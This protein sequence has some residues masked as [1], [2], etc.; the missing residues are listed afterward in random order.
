MDLVEPEIVGAVEDVRVRDLARRMADR[1]VDIVIADQIFELL[2]EIFAEVA[3]AGDAD[4]VAAGLVQSAEG[5]RR[6]IGRLV[7]AV[8]DAELGISEQAARP[9]L[10]IGPLAAQQIMGQRPAQGG[11]RLVEHLAKLVDDRRNGL[12]VAQ[13]FP[14]RAFPWHGFPPGASPGA[15]RAVIASEHRDEAIQLSA[16]RPTLLLDCR[17]ATLLAMTAEAI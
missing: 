1:N 14:F 13:A 3:R 7:I 17:V 10:G 4:R 12:K 15:S 5:A 16:V 11:D 8:V 6:E 9:R 2:G